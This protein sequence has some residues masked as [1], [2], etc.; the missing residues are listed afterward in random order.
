MTPAM[1]FQDCVVLVTGAGV[2]IGYALCRA[3]AEAG[4]YVALND[5]DA[6]LAERSA[7]TLNEALGREQVR[8]YGLDV[9][10]VEAVRAMVADVAA[11][12]G[13]LD[14]AIAN[15]GITNYGRFLEYTPDAF[16]RVMGVNLRGSYF[17]AQAAAQAMVAQEATDGRIL[18]LSSVTGVQA[19]P[20]LSTY[21]ISKAGI[22]HMA[23]VLALELS[24]HGITVNALCPGATVTERTLADDPHYAAHWASVTP[25]GRPADVRDI[26]AAALFL[27]APATRHITGQMLQID[28]GWTIYSPLSDEQPDLPEASSRLP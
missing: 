23:R 17:T 19:L 10:D 8:P 26:A 13:R 15:A 24:P 3:F 12:H 5:L 14:V 1:T 16:D 28:G 20:N 22:R 9:A 21:G 6:A 7:H 4:A 25:L 2:G 11:W 27:A 18:L